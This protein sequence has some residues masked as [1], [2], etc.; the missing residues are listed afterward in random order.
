MQRLHQ[1]FQQ[2]RRRGGEDQAL[3][4]CRKADRQRRPR[5][6]ADRHAPPWRRR[7]LRALRAAARPRPLPGAAPSLADKAGEIRRDILRLGPDCPWALR[8][9]KEDLRDL[10]G[11]RLFPD[12]H[13][14]TVTFT[15]NA[16]GVRPLQGRHRL[17]QRVPAPGQRPQEAQRRPGPDRVPA[18][19]RQLDPWRFTNRSRGRLASSSDLLEELEDLPPAQRAKRLAQLQGASATPSRKRTTSTKRSATSLIDEFTA[20][21]ELDQLRAEIAALH[22]LV[23]Q[24]RAC[25]R[26]GRRLQADRAPRVPRRS[27]SSSELNDGRGKLLIFTEHRDTLN[28]LRQHLEQWGYS[29]CQIHGGMNPHERKRAQEDFRTAKQICVATEAAGEGINLQFCR[30]DDQLRPAV[31]PDP[32]RAAAWPHPPHRAGARLPRLQLR[33]RRFRGRP[34][35]H[36]GPHP[37]AAAGEARPD[38]GGARRPR[39]RRHRR[40]AFAERREP[41][42]DAARGWPTTPAGWTSTSTTS[43]GSTRRCSRHYET[44][45]RASPS[46]APT[47]TSP[48]SRTPTLEAEERRL[49]PKYVED[50]SSSPATRSG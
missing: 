32:A 25:P 10:Y 1:A 22:E 36:R 8:R 12:R 31:E 29:T 41:A 21:A 15:L 26:P 30:S 13:A 18:P 48:A 4:A 40:S 33:R 50:S 27:P 44:G 6:A 9:L 19:A 47:W 37:R 38:A 39:L 3:P 28:H 5:P 35:H 45:H 46:L 14:H 42:R 17:H 49:M 43:S 24:A 2:S 7:P 11:H 23:A 20:A 34:A 16:R